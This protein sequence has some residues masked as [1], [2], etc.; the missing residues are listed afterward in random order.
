MSIHGTLPEKFLNQ[1]PIK[2]ADEAIKLLRGDPCKNTRNFLVIQNEI[3]W[4]EIEV[5]GREVGLHQ[6]TNH[7][8]IDTML[9]RSLVKQG[10][11]LK[12]WHPVEY[13]G[14]QF[15]LKNA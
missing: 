12:K 1:I 9:A 7:Y 15:E 14:E 13:G 6:H 8:L 3:A 5:Y 2:D 10:V 4:I 11:V